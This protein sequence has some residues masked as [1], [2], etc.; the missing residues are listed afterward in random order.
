[1]SSRAPVVSFVVPCYNLAHYLRDCIESILAQ[2]YT[3]FEI[4]IMDDCSPDD[5]AA[6]AASLTDERVQYIRNPQNLRH[7]QNYNKGIQMSRGKYLW[8]ISADDRLR[9]PTALGNLVALLDTN[10]QM[11]LACAPGILLFS[12]GQEGKTIGDNG[13]NR[14]IYSSDEFLHESIINNIVVTPGVLV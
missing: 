9:I 1:M 13:T 3:D 10:P 14:R 11:S 6:V 4:L 2:E 7:L 8:L 5:T 12:D